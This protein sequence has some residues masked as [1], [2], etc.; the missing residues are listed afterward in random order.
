MRQKTLLQINVTANWG[1]TG[2]IAE[3][4]GKTA[5]RHG[6]KSYIAYGR[7][8]NPSANKLIRIGNRFDTFLHFGEQRIFDNEGL[9]SRRATRHF[10]EKIEEIKPDVIQLHNIHDHYINYRLLLNI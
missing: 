2:K 4:I 8:S 9:C 3:E 6:W 1:S 10:I 7:Y 5:M